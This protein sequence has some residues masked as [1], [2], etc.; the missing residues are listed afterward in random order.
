M[1]GAAVIVQHHQPKHHRH[2]VRARD[3]QTKRCARASIGL[4]RQ[5]PQARQDE[6]KTE[7][8]KIAGQEKSRNPGERQR[9]VVFE[10]PDEIRQHIR[11][12][13]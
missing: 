11:L 13:L 5:F 1:A 7:Q 6:K 8:E 2:G 10:E 4:E 3:F 9:Q 12:V